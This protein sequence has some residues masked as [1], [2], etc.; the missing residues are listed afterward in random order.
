VATPS[1]QLGLFSPRWEAPPPPH[2]VPQQPYEDPFLR[3]CQERLSGAGDAPLTFDEDTWDHEAR[4][5]VGIDVEVFPNF[6]VICLKRFSDGKRLAFE[7]SARVDDITARRNLLLE[8]LTRSVT[9]S[10]NGLS[11]D[12]PVIYMALS[13]A[14]CERIKRLSDL[15]VLEGTRPWDVERL[16]GVRVPRLNHVDLIE[17]NP[18]VRQGLKMLCGRLHGRYIVDLPFAPGTY[19]T[20]HQMNVTTLYCCHSDLDATELL[21]R[22][23]R[24]PLELRVALGKIHGVDLRSK[25]DSQIGETIVRRQVEKALGH[26]VEKPTGVS[27]V[28][29][30][31]VPEFIGFETEQLRGILGRLR[32]TN[33]SI[34]SQ[35]KAV[36][37]EWLEK[38]AVRIGRMTYSMGIGGLHSTEA[39]RGLQTTPERFLVD[40][41]V[42]SQYPSI[43][44]KLGLYPPAL[45]P[46]F[47]EV[48]SDLIRERLAAK[49]ARDAVRADGGRIALNGVYGKLGSS[50]SVL[51]APNLVVA[52]TLTGQLAILMLIERAELAGIEV[53]SANTDGVVFYCPEIR[54]DTLAEVLAAWEADTGFAT[55][56]TPYREIYNSS[57]NTYVAIKADGKVKRK[58]PVADPWREGDLR[59][60][61]MKNPQ[62]TVC[63][64][65]IV[66]LLVDG[67]PM[68][69]TIRECQ[70]PRSFVTVV[71]VSTGAQWRGNPLGRAVRYYWSLDGD[72]I[73]YTNGSR[74]VSK[75]E[76]SHPMQELLDEIPADLDYLRYCEEAARLAVDLGIRR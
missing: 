73:L 71:R 1:L 49:A 8:V 18:S 30:Y 10:F 33:F 41:D 46:K 63:S 21:Y 17:P 9:I 50:Y 32:T 57:V 29:G 3:F 60:Q 35:G 45:G 2:R 38:I 70:D 54:R 56:R 24:Q 48:Y 12:L 40:V 62:M 76:G 39:H 58:G 42:A 61:M 72:P 26:R 47:L 66:R 67:T 16:T 59:G 68:E 13:G 31:D 69:R 23:L 55:E 52:V 74:R 7:R 25:S 20:P 11:Y 64:E 53:V 14:G 6:V 28:F 37:P 4:T 19:L 36:G 15:I 65:A 51:Y 75:T 43:I 34:T 27:P 44:M 5:A 22:A